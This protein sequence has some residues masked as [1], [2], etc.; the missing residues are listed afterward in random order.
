[1]GSSPSTG[2]TTLKELEARRLRSAKLFEQG[3]SASRVA[4]EFGVTPQAAA[5][6]RKQWQEGGAEALRSTG[7][8]GRK[9]SLS[10][11]QLR[12]LEEA[13]LRGPKAHGYAT[14]LWTLKR[15]AKLIRQEFGITFSTAHVWRLIRQIGWSPQKPSRRAKERDEERIDDWKRRE[16][17]RI[18]RGLDAGKRPLS[19]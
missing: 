18:K 13:L 15:I 19:S 9:A 2:T 4:R 8:R 7:R 3:W 12:Q 14:D 10:G 17:P 5:L 11:D 1:M 16:W 6:W